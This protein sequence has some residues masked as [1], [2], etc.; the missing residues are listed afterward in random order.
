MKLFT[1]YKDCVYEKEDIR[2]NQHDVTE[3][4]SFQLPKYFEIMKVTQY[5]VNIF[6]IDELNKIFIYLL[7]FILFLSKCDVI[8]VFGLF[9][10]FLL[11]CSHIELR[12]L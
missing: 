8:S 6:H 11:T 1:H 7:M 5:K 4:N 3:I 10:L 2:K 9:F 12:P